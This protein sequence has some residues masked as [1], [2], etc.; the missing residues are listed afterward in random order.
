MCVA[1]YVVAVVVFVSLLWLL[2]LLFLLSLLWLLLVSDE[3]VFCCFPSVGCF[4]RCHR[5]FAWL[6]MLFLLLS[7]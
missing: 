2:L 1:G 5:Y 7:R 4:Y 3:G 6:L